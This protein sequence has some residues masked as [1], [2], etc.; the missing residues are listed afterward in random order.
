MIKS[1]RSSRGGEKRE[2]NP[3]AMGILPGNKEMVVLIHHLF[4]VS[5][6]WQKDN[7]LI[8]IILDNKK[9]STKPKEEEEIIRPQVKKGK[10]GYISLKLRHIQNIQCLFLRVGGCGFI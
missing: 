2:M 6:P 1:P 4:S 9:S 7:H 5:F 3:E 10:V 8:L